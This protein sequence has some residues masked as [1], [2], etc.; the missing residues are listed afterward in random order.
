MAIASKNIPDVMVVN[1]I[2]TLLLLVQN[3][4]I[5]DLT[6]AYE[7]CASPRIREIYKSYGDSILENVTFDGKLMALP[8]T[9]IAN[10]PSLLWLRK[11]WMDMLGLAEP[12]TLADAE[13]I[14][15][16]FVEKDPGGNGKGQTSGLSCDEELTGESDFS[17]E[18]Q[19]DIIFAN[20]GVYPKQWME[21]GGAEIMKEAEEKVK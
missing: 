20:Y 11:D 10:G 9:N 16:T 7:Q 6:E 18:Y 12:K 13:K 21:Q 14:I 4:M 8:E 15:R 5:E 1:D 17:D 3:D 19:T 2:D